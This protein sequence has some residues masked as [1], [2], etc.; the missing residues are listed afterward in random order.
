MIEERTPEERVAEQVT[1]WRKEIARLTDMV[2]HATGAAATDPVVEA[3]RALLL[4]RSQVGL[5][6]YGGPLAG[7]SLNR[8]QLLRHLLEELLDAG[9]YVQA[10]L[11]REQSALAAAFHYPEHWDVAAYPTL[12]SAISEV[13]AW[14]KCSECTPA[15]L[16]ASG[17]DA[18]ELAFLDHWLSVAGNPLGMSCC[19]EPAAGAE[20]MGQSEAVCCGN[21]EPVMLELDGLLAEMDKRRNELVSRARAATSEG[22][23]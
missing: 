22:Q 19:G 1:G 18:Q 14:F 20:Y 17:Q 7:S 16:S 23:G 13:V 21:G 4:E 5:K 8:S 12:E 11:M 3:N 15:V 2:A 9:N 10:E 6:K